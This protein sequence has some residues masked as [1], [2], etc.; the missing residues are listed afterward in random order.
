MTT[1]TERGI[2]EIES[3]KQHLSSFGI[4]LNLWGKGKAKTVEHLF[5]EVKS[6]EAVLEER[7]SELIRKTTVCKAE[8]FH[9]DAEGGHWHLKEEKQVFKDGRER[10]RKLNSSVSEKIKANEDP[11]ASIKRGIV[12]ELDLQGDLSVNQGET[13][14]EEEESPSY[15]GLK[16]VYVLHKFTVELAADQFKPEG[17]QE[18]QKDKTTYFVWEKVS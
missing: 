13:D 9:T 1:E 14:E 2:G 6:G 5:A 17:Y 18:D 3:L 15:P 10:V 11:L 16:T 4:N 12:E 8:V 7:E